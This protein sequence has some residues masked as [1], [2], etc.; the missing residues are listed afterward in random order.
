MRIY[1]YLVKLSGHQISDSDSSMVSKLLKVIGDFERISDHSVNVLEA[2]EELSDKKIHFTEEA[3]KE[4]STMCGA[5]SEVLTFSY[6]AFVKDDLTAARSVEPLEQVVDVLKEKLR[7]DHIA[8][9]KRGECSIE[10]GFVWADLLTDLER[11][12]DHCSNI[13]LCV[14]DA[15]DYNMNI[16]ESLRRIKKNNPEFEKKFNDYAEKYGVSV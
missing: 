13:A 2:A 16:H 11:V 1:S 8:R 10:A 14:I 5:V 7:N 15:R 6:Q 3:D 4:L 12:A 9:L